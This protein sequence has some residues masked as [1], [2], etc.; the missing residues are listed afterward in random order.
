MWAVSE[1]AAMASDLAEF[2]GGA[3]GLALLFRMPLLTG[4]AATATIT[5]TSLSLTAGVFDR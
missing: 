3:I 1:V 4:M 5:Y 2:L